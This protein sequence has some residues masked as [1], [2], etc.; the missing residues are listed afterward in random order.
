MICALI[1]NGS[2]SPT[3]MTIKML[4]G[5]RTLAV[6]TV[7]STKIMAL[8]MFNA[9]VETLSVLSAVKNLTD[10][11][12]VIK[13][14]NGRPKIQTKVK[15]SLGLWQTLSSVPNVRNLLRKIKV[16]IT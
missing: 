10:H 6:I 9:N 4:D 3:Q 11:A 7:L 13:Q 16:A 15:T 12:H 2:A 14:C 5:A 8:A 1:I